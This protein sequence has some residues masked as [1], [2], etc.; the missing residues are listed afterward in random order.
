MLSLHKVR[1]AQGRTYY[2]EEN[3][4]ANAQQEHTEWHGKGA[5]ILGLQGKVGVTDFENLLEGYDRQGIPLIQQKNLGG[6]DILTTSEVNKILGETGVILRSSGL[7]QSVIADINSQFA[8]TIVQGKRLHETQIRKFKKGI[9]ESITASGLTFSQSQ[10]LKEALYQHIDK[11]R[12]KPQRRAATDLTFSAP[13]S[14]SLAALVAGDHRLIEAHRAAVR[15]SLEVAEKRY[16]LARTGGR[17]ARKIESTENFVTALFEHDAAR[18]VGGAPP[19]PQLHTHALIFNMTRVDENGVGKWMALH[20]DGLFNASKLLGVV[21][22]N[23]LARR[24]K[25]LGYTITP[26]K[27]GTFEIEGYR[28]KDLELFSKRREQIEAQGATTQ[29][30]ARA[31]VLKG[32][33]SKGKPISRQELVADWIKQAAAIALRHPQPLAKSASKTIGSPFQ[34]GPNDS[35]EKAF[36]RSVS[37][38]ILELGSRT[39]RF[40]RDK[41]EVAAVAKMLGERKF[42]AWDKAL[43][44]REGRELFATDKEG[45]ITTQRA[46]N[47]EVETVQFLKNGRATAKPILSSDAAD[48]YISSVNALSQKKGGRGLTKGQAEALLLAMTTEDRII[49]WQG[50]AGVGKSYSL[51]AFRELAQARGYEFRGFAPSA[52]AAK[53]LAQE[54][55]LPTADTVA[56]LLVK[57]SPTAKPS[58]TEIWIVDE[59]G[60]LSQRDAYELLRRAELANARVLLVGDTKQISAVEQ[61]L[62]FQLLQD[63][64]MK[65]ALMEESIRQKDQALKAAINQIARGN[66]GEAITALDAAGK[67]HEFALDSQRQNQIAKMYLS[68]TTEAR[69]ETITI[70]D[71]HAERYS[72]IEKIREGLKAEGVLKNETKVEF[73]Q[74]KDASDVSLTYAQTY[75]RGDILI[76]YQRA[77]GL[78]SNQ[79]YTVLSTDTKANTLTLESKNGHQRIVN[80]DKIHVQLFTSEKHEIAEGDRVRWTKNHLSESGEK[81]R[82]GQEGVVSRVDVA[83]GTA[84]ITYPDGKKDEFRLSAR[85]HLDHNVVTTTHASQGKTYDHALIS[86][87][88]TSAESFYVGASRSRYSL[89]VFT[90]NKDELI[91]QATKSKAN[92]IASHVLSGTEAKVLD[93][94][95]DKVKERHERKIPSPELTLSLER[96]RRS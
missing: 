21:Y 44:E 41:L 62:P 12:E 20:N 87:D 4:Y 95:K 59:A 24:V 48:R 54:A 60:M 18:P 58:G 46:L 70:A 38:G 31:A 84:E 89:E 68:R 53:A 22:Q 91:K 30:Q 92:E 50:D 63:N 56:S 47:L 61:G 35:A 37:D 57:D 40:T 80:V 2:T 90:K 77:E 71:T 11:T 66:I 16:A 14:V 52:E 33:A 83:K 78:K 1:A 7:A 86:T 96:K 17:K 74:K 79:E 69:R 94:M 64:G 25:E 6:K 13:K 76:P 75:S 93:D 88:M 43:T 49:A 55:R 27:N 42:A 81:R 65:T 8:S 85:Q 51:N 23:E 32:R 5:D 73:L 45:W 28:E 26:N 3:Y 34:T 9:R 36:R 15:E 39:T 29:K 67:I 10:A 19:D 72:I 82:N